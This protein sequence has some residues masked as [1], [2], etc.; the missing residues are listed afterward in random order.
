MNRVIDLFE[1]KNH[2]KLSSAREIQFN[3]KITSAQ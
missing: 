3:R 2:K 1:K